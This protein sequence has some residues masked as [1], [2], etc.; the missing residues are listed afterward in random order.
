MEEDSIITRIAV[1]ADVKYVYQI[2]DTMDAG[3]KERGTGI[4]RRP[5]QYLCRKIYEGKA[6]I[7]VTSDS[8]WAGFSYL[9]SWSNNAFVSNS[10]LIVHPAFRGKGI[11]SEIKKMIFDLSKKLYPDANIFSI[12]TGAA[13]LKLNFDLG[14]Q[15]VTFSDIT[16]D[17]KFWEQC[18]SCANHSI[19]ESTHRKMCLCTAMVKYSS[20]VCF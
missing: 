1:P 19:L 2:L 10:G 5:V 16:Q 3:A 18:K 7:S 17:E 11:A 8:A 4:A 9:E 12:T 14:F 15:P 6:V 13:V 20:K